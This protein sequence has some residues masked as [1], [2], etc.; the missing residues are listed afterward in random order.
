MEAAQERLENGEDI[1]DPNQ[2]K[3]AALQAEN[4]ANKEQIVA[5]EDKI[6]VCNC[7]RIIN[8]LSDLVHSV[9][10]TTIEW[11][12]IIVVII[13]V[14]KLVTI[15]IVIINITQKEY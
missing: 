10:L 11:L 9:Q 5:R 7:G 12:A 1:I 6:L 3:L 8:G 2:A 13:I 14:I 15:T 4:D